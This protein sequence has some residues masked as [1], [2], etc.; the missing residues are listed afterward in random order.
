[1]IW[2]SIVRQYKCSHYAA[3]HL[4]DAPYIL[5]V[6]L[7]L[8]RVHSDPRLGYRRRGVVLGWEYVTARPLNLAGTNKEQILFVWLT[9]A[10]S[11]TDKDSPNLQMSFHWLQ[12]EL[13]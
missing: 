5:L 2:F 1:M 8:P 3:V 4:V 11:L 12:N 6:C 9:T 13:S 7:S 10:K